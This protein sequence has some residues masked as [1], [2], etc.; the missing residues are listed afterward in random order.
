MIQV[1]PA[2]TGKLKDWRSIRTDGEQYQTTRRTDNTFVK[3]SC[4]LDT[5]HYPLAFS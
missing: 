4:S 2:N 3:R 5:L 1:A